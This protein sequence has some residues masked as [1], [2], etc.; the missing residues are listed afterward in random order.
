MERTLG[1]TRTAS[2]VESLVLLQ[3]RGGV[4][5]AGTG[6]DQSRSV[7]GLLGMILL[8]LLFFFCFFFKFF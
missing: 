3:I 2:L 8:F 7:L 5:T 4:V 1:R 6:V